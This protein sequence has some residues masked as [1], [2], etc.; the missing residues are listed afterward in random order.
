[1]EYDYLFKC[2]LIG[3]SG[4]GKS[5]IVSR[6][7]DN[8]FENSYISTIGVDFKIKTIKINDKIVKLQMWDTAG[9]ERFRNITSSY[10]RGSHIIIICY[11]ITDIQSFNNINIWLDEIE[12]YASDKVTIVLCGTKTDMN[13]RR[14]VSYEEAKYYADMHDIKYFETSSKDDVDIT[15]IFNDTIIEKMIL[16]NIVSTN[17]DNK[18]KLTDDRINLNNRS[19]CF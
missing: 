16:H 9:Q 12:K 17:K 3:D 11:D 15:K 8:T 10:Y 18:Y 4:V 5:S 2:L 19:C 6:F 13:F 14:Q 7:V 1:M